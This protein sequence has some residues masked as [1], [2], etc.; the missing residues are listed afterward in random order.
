MIIQ[1][2]SYQ[3]EAVSALWEYFGTKA[4]NPVVAMPTGT[5]KSV[6]I[7]MFLESVFKQYRDQKILVL[8]HVKELI[9]Q[10]YTKLVQLWPGAPAGINSAGLGKR[11]THDRIIFA[12]IGS[13]AKHAGQ[14]GRVDLVLIDE[15]HLVS[16]K[17]ATMYQ[18]FLAALKEGNPYLK[19]IGFTATPWRLG[20]G[21]ITAGEGS[22]F[23]DVAFDITGLAAFN[24]LI[25]EGYLAPLVPRRTGTLLSV[26]GVHMRG[27]E[28]IQGELQKAVD[29]DEVTEAALKE[30]MQMGGDRKHWLIFASGVQHAENIANMLSSMGVPAVAIHSKMGD[31]PRDAA[32]RDFKAGRYVA[33][34]N[35]NVLTTGFD[36]PCIDFI[37]MLRP[38]ASPVLW[39]QMLGRGTRPCKCGCGKTD[40]LVGDFAGNTRRLG[41]INDPV[42]PG[43]KGKGGGEAP[44]KECSSENL[45]KD[46]DGVLPLGCNTYNHTSV[47]NCTSCGAEFSFECKLQYE[48]SSAPI[49]KGDLPI[50][51]VF[52]VQHITYTQHNKQ[53]K[54]PAMRV[55]YYCGLH[56]YS[57]YVCLQ[58]GGFAAKK[59]RD[60]WRERSTVPAPET[61]EEALRLADGLHVVTHLRVWVNTKYPQIMAHCYDGTA[62]GTQVASDSDEGPRVEVDRPGTTRGYATLITDGDGKTTTEYYDDDIPF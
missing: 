37:L 31:D 28:F 36:F 61:T 16:P 55:S 45:K 34:V 53:G 40:C 5:G 7:A 27:N 1:A 49:I 14:F 38:T 15:A 11:D 30:A 42:I 2:R 57:E 62:F 35:N 22:I 39:V 23:T 60:W 21:S 4:G 32:I 58:H 47:R 56:S 20:Q 29:K 13:V 17:E 44:V 54:P 19:V 43:P 10:N 12:G 26:D 52:K 18:N 8:T 46:K 3:A 25:A 33:A 24:R 6:V 9:E 51:E 41:P 50:V 48:A 59:G